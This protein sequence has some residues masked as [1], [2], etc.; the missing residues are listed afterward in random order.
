[1]F[2]DDVSDFLTRTCANF[3]YGQQN[4]TKT[5]VFQTGAWDLSYNNIRRI[6]ETSVS[7]RKL[8]AVLTSILEGRWLVRDCNTWSG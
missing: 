1:M 2:A 7:A 3:P 8:I 6:T 5:I 4:S